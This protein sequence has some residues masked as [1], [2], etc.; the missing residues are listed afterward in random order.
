MD[1]FPPDETTY[2]GRTSEQI[3]SKIDDILALDENSMRNLVTKGKRLIA[4]CFSPV[5]EDALAVFRKSKEK[6]EFNVKT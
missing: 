1:W 5:T 6:E 2:V 4:Q 3:S